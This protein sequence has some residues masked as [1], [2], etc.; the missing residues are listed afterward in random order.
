MRGMVS[1]E[2]PPEG[3]LRCHQSV[4]DFRDSRGGAAM[5]LG[6][7]LI[8]DGQDQFAGSLHNDQVRIRNRTLVRLHEKH[9]PHSTGD[10]GREVRSGSDCRIGRL[11]SILGR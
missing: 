2:N 6:L 5:R 8:I 9:Q 1:D 7:E 4:T 11:P 3:N 10:T